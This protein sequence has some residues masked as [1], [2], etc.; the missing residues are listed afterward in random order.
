M[1]GCVQQK[2]H[3]KYA[4]IFQYNSRHL[5]NLN[6]THKQIKSSN[7]GTV[8]IIPFIFFAFHPPV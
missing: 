6:P 5:A 2:Q 4:Y 1:W 8:F 7:S 3:V